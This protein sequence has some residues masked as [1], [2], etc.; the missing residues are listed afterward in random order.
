MKMSRWM[1][2]AAGVMG[3]TA[4]VAGTF[5]A[6]Y[7]P[8]ESLDPD[9]PRWWDTGAKYHLAHAPVLLGLAVWSAFV[10]AGAK[11]LTTASAVCFCVGVTIF[12]GSLYVMSLTGV[13]W[14][15]AITPIG[16]LSLMA[17]WGLLVVAGCRGGVKGSPGQ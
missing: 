14:L 9:A 12:A 4:I 5:A 11:K 7:L 17:G 2:I 8:W 10:T 3:F 15:G 13:R 16:G 6:H 1:L